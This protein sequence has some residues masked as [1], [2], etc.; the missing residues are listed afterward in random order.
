MTPDYA[1][2]TRVLLDPL[3]PGGSGHS[4]GRSSMSTQMCLSI[5]PR[6]GRPASILL[7]DGIL[8]HRPELRRY[9]NFSVFLHVEWMRNHRTPRARLSIRE[10]AQP[11]ERASVLIDNDDLDRPSIM[12]PP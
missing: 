1:T 3:G 12:R 11:D 9:C 10:N 5:R 2:L 8:L 6:A 7:F 4:G